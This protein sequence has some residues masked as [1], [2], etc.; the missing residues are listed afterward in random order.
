MIDA[1]DAWW[2]DVEHVLSR[3]PLHLHQDLHI[4]IKHCRES[5]GGEIA[6]CGSFLPHFVAN[7]PNKGKVISELEC[8]TILKVLKTI[9]A[10]CRRILRLAAEIQ[11]GPLGINLRQHTILNYFKPIH[12]TVNKTPKSHNSLIKLK[13]KKTKDLNKNLNPHDIFHT[14]PSLTCNDVLYWEFKAG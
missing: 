1:L 10:G 8:R 14:T 11:R 12:T 5:P 2:R 4:I 13:N 7:L 6:C 3:S 9:G